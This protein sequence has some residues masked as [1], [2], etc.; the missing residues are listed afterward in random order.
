MRWNG[1]EEMLVNK[2]E[3]ALILNLIVLSILHMYMQL[4]IWLYFMWVDFKI[5]CLQHLHTR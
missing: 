3:K 4:H 1:R 5:L 2:N